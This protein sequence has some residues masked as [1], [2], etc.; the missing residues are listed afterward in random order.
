MLR[1][2]MDI[3]HW[4]LLN[5][6]VNSYQVRHVCQRTTAAQQLMS[7]SQT[8]K[9]GDIVGLFCMKLEESVQSKT[10][11]TL[12]IPVMRQSFG[13]FLA[14]VLLKFASSRDQVFFRQTRPVCFLVNH[15][16][17]QFSPWSCIFCL[18]SFHIDCSLCSCYFVPFKL[19]TI[20]SNN[21]FE[22]CWTTKALCSCF[23][24]HF[25][26]PCLVVWFPSGVQPSHR[27]GPDC[28]QWGRISPTTQNR[29]RSS[30]AEG[31]FVHFVFCFQSF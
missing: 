28:L 6:R 13:I 12:R 10:I 17:A 25:E 22:L 31:I 30:A 27:R 1:G 5:V 8:C 3:G 21:F 14:L 15:T 19:T 9:N 16:I 26:Q 11:W 7:Q 23:F 4:I 24:C 20:A 29:Q 18:H 2:L